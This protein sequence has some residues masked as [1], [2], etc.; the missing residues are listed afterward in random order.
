M[1]QSESLSNL[2]AALAQV[3][4]EL[5]PA[6]ENATNPFFKSKYADIASII[7]AAREEAKVFETQAAGAGY[8]PAASVATDMDDLMIEMEAAAEDSHDRGA[9]VKSRKAGARDKSRGK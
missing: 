5:R 1:N 2:A 7:S 4:G 9:M 3:Q 8:A 6:E